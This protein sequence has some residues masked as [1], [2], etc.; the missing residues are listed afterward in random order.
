MTAKAKKTPATFAALYPSMVS[1][2]RSFNLSEFAFFGFSGEKPLFS[3]VL[4]QDADPVTIR[5][6]VFCSNNSAAASKDED[7]GKPNPQALDFAVLPPGCDTLLIDGTVVATSESL[8]LHSC[9]SNEFKQAYVDFVEAFNKAGG[10]AMLAERYVMNMVNGAFLFRNRLGENVR[11]AVRCAGNT[12]E[13]RESDLKSLGVLSLQDV[14]NAEVRDKL[15][16]IVGKMTDALTGK[17]RAM[18]F[19]VRCSAVMG[20]GQ[21]VYPSQE[22]P[23]ES[24]ELKSSSDSKRGYKDGR[25]LARALRS[26]GLSQVAFHARKASNALR[27][28]DTWWPSATRA[29]PVEPFGVDRSTQSA[30]RNN[31]HEFYSIVMT[32]PEMTEQLL[33]NNITDNALFTMAVYLRGGVF[34]KK[35]AEKKDSTTAESEE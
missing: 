22:F 15:Q 16:T 26:D 1:S 20:H 24:V 32:M 25:Y 7:R 28:I 27:S 17:S 31:E 23:L 2:K 5:R 3:L 12:V 34:S 21:E 6:E 9:N 13:V 8:E 18:V 4:G 11:C 30:M 10:M 33:A 35:A 19:D 29:L 14:T